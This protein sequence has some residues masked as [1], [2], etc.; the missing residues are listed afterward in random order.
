MI[1]IFMDLFSP[2]NR[3]NLPD[4]NPDSA[5]KR[6]MWAASSGVPWLDTALLF[7]H[8]IAFG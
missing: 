6:E 3:T 7:E 1:E 8:G 4:H 2:S 5:A